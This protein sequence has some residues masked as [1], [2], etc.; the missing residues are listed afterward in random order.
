M[1]S[2]AHITQPSGTVLVIFAIR[3]RSLIMLLISAV[4][5]ISGRPPWSAVAVGRRVPSGGYHHPAVT[6]KETLEVSYPL[7]G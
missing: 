1:E 3:G 6:S 4:W 5:R 2:V 7:V